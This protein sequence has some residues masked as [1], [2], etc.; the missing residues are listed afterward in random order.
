[1]RPEGEIRIYESVDATAVGQVLTQAGISVA[2][3]GVHRQD[4][5]DY[6]LDKMGGADHV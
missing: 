1:M 6:F 4:L 3:M 5:E 2:E